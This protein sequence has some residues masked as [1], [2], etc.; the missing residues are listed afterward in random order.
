MQL[1]NSI[2][3]LNSIFSVQNE[4]T[5]EN[6]GWSLSSICTAFAAIAI[7]FAWTR[8][9]LIAYRSEAK[10]IRL[11]GEL[12]PRVAKLLRQKD[13]AGL[14]TLAY[15]RFA[16]GD[17]ST[18]RFVSL[19]PFLFLSH[20]VRLETIAILILKG[21]REPKL[22]PRNLSVKPTPSWSEKWSHDGEEVVE[23]SHGGGLRHIQEFLSG[24]SLG[25]S[26]EAGSGVGL[27]VSPYGSERDMSYAL[28]TS[29]QHFDE[30]ALFKAKIKAKYLTAAPNQYEAGLK[31]DAIQ[32]LTDISV[33]AI[34]Q[35]GA[36]KV[37]ILQQLPAPRR[38]RVEDLGEGYE[39]MVS[40]VNSIIEG[41]RSLIFGV[42][43]TAVH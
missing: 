43:G 3:N 40:E 22:A 35:S 26:L 36:T 25:Y 18:N 38:L 17:Y 6:Q 9:R 24:K 37:G 15:E 28:R 12:G 42:Y 2:Y 14:K 39:E 11:N 29:I 10:L 5:S 23:I 19:L 7:V 8:S 16:K 30:P 33:V 13:K 1:I 32:H 4:K 21:D 31:A 27:Q 34:Q 41:L 20:A